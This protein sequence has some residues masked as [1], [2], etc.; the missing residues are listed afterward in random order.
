[1][2]KTFIYILSIIVISIIAKPIIAQDFN[3][4][5]FNQVYLDTYVNKAI[6]YGYCTADGVR[7]SIIF[8]HNYNRSLKDYTIDSNLVLSVN[9]K[10]NDVQITIVFATWCPDSQREV[11]RFIEILRVM[12]YPVDMLNIIAVDRNKTVEE[13]DIKDLNVNFVPTFIFSKNDVEIGRIVEMPVS[14]LE[15][16]IVEILFKTN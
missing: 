2:K 9:E 7:E 12:D 3:K 11:P 1:M 15:S 8:R 16:D 10:L 13:I 6:L 5:S 14:T 4:E